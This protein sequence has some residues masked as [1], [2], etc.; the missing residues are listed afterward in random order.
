LIAIVLAFPLAWWVMHQW[1]MDFVYRT[2]I[3][4][5]IFIIAGC[6]ALLI[7]FIT[8]SLLA[9]RA[10]GSNPVKSLRSE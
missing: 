9:V 5:W 1:L 8:V 10:S 4:W 7:A 2:Q 3:S 6:M